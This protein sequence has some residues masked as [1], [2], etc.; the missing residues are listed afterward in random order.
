MRPNNQNTVGGKCKNAISDPKN[1]RHFKRSRSFK[2]KFADK[3]PITPGNVLT[4]FCWNNQ[5]R[6]AKKVQ[7]YDFFNLKCLPFRPKFYTAL[8]DH[9]RY[10]CA[11]YYW[12]LCKIEG[13]RSRT[14]IR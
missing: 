3:V 9:L 7:K 12:E 4:K 6:L 13:A 10:R 8:R 1:G 2:V 5:N 14:K 11:I